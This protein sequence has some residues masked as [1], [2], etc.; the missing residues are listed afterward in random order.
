LGRAP[1]RCTGPS[2]GHGA[3]PRASPARRCA[4]RC[5]RAASAFSYLPSS[6]PVDDR[7]VRPVDDGG[8]AAAHL[9]RR[10]AQRDAV[11]PGRPCVVPA[12]RLAMGHARVRARHVG[13]R[14]DVAVRPLHSPTF[15]RRA[16]RTPS[17]PKRR[18]VAAR[19]VS[20]LIS[21]SIRARRPAGWRPSA[22]AA[23]LHSA[24]GFCRAV[25]QVRVDRRG[26]APRVDARRWFA[27]AADDDASGKPEGARARARS[28]EL[29]AEKSASRP[30]H[31]STP[32][33]RRSFE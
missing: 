18:S 10:A 24:A 26:T 6:G 11:A 12:R 29:R 2:A 23:L 17:T 15:R 32:H 31:S 9:P 33:R 27:D 7:P 3:R 21:L 20:F 19:R 30:R 4:R 16:P 28:A 5:R 14:A 22:A 8:E 25:K 13:V 1:V